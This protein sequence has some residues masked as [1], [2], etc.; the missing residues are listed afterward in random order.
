MEVGGS[1]SLVQCCQ[2]LPS[3]PKVAWAVLKLKVLDSELPYEG[4]Y[5]DQDQSGITDQHVLEDVVLRHCV[6]LVSNAD[7]EEK[8]MLWESR[9]CNGDRNGGG[10]PIDDSDQDQEVDF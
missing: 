10:N 7:L 3:L 4:E 6:L 8:K 5:C 1:K 9:I 2:V